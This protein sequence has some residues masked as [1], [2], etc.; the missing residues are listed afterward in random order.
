MFCTPA[1]TV[2]MIGKMPWLTPN[3]ILD[4]GPDAEIEDEQRQDGDLRRAVEQQDDRHEAAV[5]ANARQP[6]REPDREPDHDREREGDRELPERD[7]A[8]PPARPWV[9]NT[10]PSDG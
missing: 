8:A 1:T 4:G 3:A 6:D 7:A 5:A 2:T 9:S 10:S